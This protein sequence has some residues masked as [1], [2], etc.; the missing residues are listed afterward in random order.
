MDRD[1]I[2]QSAGND[3][4]DNNTTVT[5]HVMTNALGGSSA[6][7]R[8]MQVPLEIIELEID[9]SVPRDIRIVGQ[10]PRGKRRKRILRIT[11][12][13]GVQLT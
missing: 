6:T 13:G 4:S 11:A 2:R 10:T 12:E 1:E 9:L 3:A 7:S 8:L 5:P